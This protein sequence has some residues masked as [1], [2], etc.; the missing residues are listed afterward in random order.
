MLL[1]TLSPQTILPVGTEV[2][3]EIAFNFGWASCLWAMVNRALFLMGCA[4]GSLLGSIQLTDVRPIAFAICCLQ[5]LL[6][7]VVTFTSWSKN[8]ILSG[9]SSIGPF[10]LLQ[11]F[12]GCWCQAHQSLQ[13]A[14]LI[15]IWYQTD[16]RMRK[17][18]VCNYTQMWPWIYQKDLGHG[19]LWSSHS[20]ECCRT[21]PPP[22]LQTLANILLPIQWHS[23]V[24]KDLGPRV[25]VLHRGK[26]RRSTW[27]WLWQCRQRKVP[28][29]TRCLNLQ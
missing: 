27:Q 13:L 12:V 22:A 3:M 21:W 4:K 23:P 1:P 24:Q 28:C 29:C 10:V 18:Q 17:V 6:A 8:N 9:D 15:F 7:M 20:G 5:D 11:E 2:E 16:D 25:A 19:W 26:S 14:A